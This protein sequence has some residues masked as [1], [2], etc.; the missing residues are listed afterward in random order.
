M[1][2]RRIETHDFMSFRFA[3]LR[4][5]AARNKGMALFPRKVGGRYAM[6]A[7]Q[8]KKNLYLIH[9]DDLYTWDGGQA[10]MKLE[11]PREF[12]QIGNCGSPIEL[13]EGWLLLTH[14][15][16]NTRSG[17]RCSTRLIPQRCW[18]ALASRCCG[19]SRRSA[20]DTSPTSSIPAGRN[21]TK[22]R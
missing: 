7:Q 9:S 15:C 6:I 18:R 13:D 10:I 21:G 12:V 16:A 20:K 4:G 8:D 11:F 22:I 2:K 1:M 14:R 17:R 5:S 3:P 19:P